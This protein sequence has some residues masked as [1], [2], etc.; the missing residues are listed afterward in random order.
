[1]LNLFVPSKHYSLKANDPLIPRFFVEDPRLSRE[2]PLHL[3]A[4]RLGVSLMIPLHK[5]YFHIFTEEIM[6]SARFV[7]SVIPA[8]R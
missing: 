6:L 5:S 1:M 7:K 3:W 2:F 4:I 8:L